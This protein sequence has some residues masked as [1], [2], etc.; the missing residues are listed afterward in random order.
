MTVAHAGFEGRVD[1][2]NPH[3]VDCPGTRW[4]ASVGD[5]S[6][7][8]DLAIVMGPAAVVP[9]IL[10]R[11]FTRT[12]SLKSLERNILKFVGIAPL[13]R[14]IIG[15]IEGDEDIR[16]YWLKAMIEAGRAGQ[17]GRRSRRYLRIIAYSTHSI[18]PL[19]DGRRR[20]FGQGDERAGSGGY[21][22]PGAASKPC[23]HTA[24][25]LLPFIGCVFNPFPAPLCAAG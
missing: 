16:E 23:L 24:A 15:N 3:R 19:D 25:R 10:H 20:G 21:I 7:P 5:L 13:R 9:A 6:A 14:S 18:A 2:A 8:P 12:H 22:A 11:S 17:Q 1:L 4:V